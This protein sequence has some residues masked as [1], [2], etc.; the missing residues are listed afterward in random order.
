MVTILM[1][2]AEMATQ[3]LLKERYF[4]TKFMMS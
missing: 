1:M 4:E 3:S 2:S